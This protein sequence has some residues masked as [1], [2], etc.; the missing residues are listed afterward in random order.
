M[1]F[2]RLGY[3]G[4]SVKFAEGDMIIIEMSESVLKEP[5]LKQ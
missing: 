1:Y 5:N 2:A 3:D 4:Y